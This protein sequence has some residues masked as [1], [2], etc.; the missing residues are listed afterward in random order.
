MWRR[1]SSD[2]ISGVSGSDE[3]G[4]GG[5]VSSRSSIVSCIGIVGVG[6]G[7][8][9][10]SRRGI[11]GGIVGISGSNVNISRSDIVSGISRSSQGDL[12]VK[13]TERIKNEVMDSD[14]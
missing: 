4:I 9:I 5:A 6:S 3:V 10:V 14:G 11:V 8:G 12:V 1:E 7:S 13:D 2:V